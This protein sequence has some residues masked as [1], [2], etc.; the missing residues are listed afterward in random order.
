MLFYIDWKDHGCLTMS[1]SHHKG[2][3]RASPHAAAAPPG[4]L[5]CTAGRCT[6][7]S[8]L[9]STT[10]YHQFSTTPP[11]IGKPCFQYLASISCSNPC[12]NL[13]SAIW[14]W[15]WLPPWNFSKTSSVLEAITNG[16]LLALG[17]GGHRGILI[18]LV[19]S[20][21]LWHE[22]NKIRKIIDCG[23]FEALSVKTIIH[24]INKKMG[25]LIWPFGD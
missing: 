22:K 4:A 11:I 3:N 14:I 13:K 16:Q 25:H 5:Q 19:M 21:I 10:R 18:I 12:W 20:V 1:S 2:N 7:C 6:L 23:N 15:K 9:Y 17:E 24:I 8:T